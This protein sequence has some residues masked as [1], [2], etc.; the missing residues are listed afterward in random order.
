[1]TE[2]TG[3]NRTDEQLVALAVRAGDDPE[4]RRAA[5]ELLARHQRRVYLWC[6]RYV[7]EHERA[8]ELAQETLLNAYRSLSTF[9]GRSRFTSWLFVIARNRC[10][11]AVA[12]PALLRDDGADPDR[13]AVESEDPQ[14][15]FEGEQ[16]AERLRRL[17]MECLDEEEREALWLRCFEKVPVD[18]IGA[19]MR[20]DNRSGARGLLQR[21][22]R[23]LRAAL[24]ERDTG[25]RA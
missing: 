21:A 4:S 20:L 13:I 15:L 18:E 5:S 6:Y 16:G 10:L 7:R 24:Y 19:V 23:K 9:E 22:R 17:L 2:P 11:N 14:V 25:G 8:L 1:M 3:S 12:S